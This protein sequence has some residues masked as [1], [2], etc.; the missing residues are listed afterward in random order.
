ML[1]AFESYALP[2][3]NIVKELKQKKVHYAAAGTQSGEG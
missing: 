3:D 2:N 1:E